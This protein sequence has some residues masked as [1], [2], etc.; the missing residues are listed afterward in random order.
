MSTT[1]GISISMFTIGGFRDVL[2]EDSQDCFSPRN[3]N[4]HIDLTLYAQPIFK[5]P[6]I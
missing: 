1:F 5:T 3:I 6:I 4:F 2:S